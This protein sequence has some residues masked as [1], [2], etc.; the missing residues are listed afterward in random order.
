[1]SVKETQLIAQAVWALVDLVKLY[2]QKGYST[3]EDLQK[4]KAKLKELDDLLVNQP[5]LSEYGE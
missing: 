1:M 4:A 2:E 5:P 3:S